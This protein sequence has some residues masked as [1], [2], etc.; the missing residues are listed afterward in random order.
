MTRELLRLTISTLLVAWTL[1]TLTELTS[2]LDS[3]IF[4]H[5]KGTFNLAGTDIKSTI[6]NYLLVF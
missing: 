1:V 3:I 4:F 2:L 6:R 5:F